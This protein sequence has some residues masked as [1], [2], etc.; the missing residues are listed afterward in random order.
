MAPLPSTQRRTMRWIAAKQVA[1]GV[2]NVAN[3]W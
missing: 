3:G 2:A 1:I